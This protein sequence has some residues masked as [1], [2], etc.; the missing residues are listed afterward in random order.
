MSETDF[1]EVTS[2]APLILQVNE[3]RDALQRL[4]VEKRHLE[5]TSRAKSDFFATLSHELRTPLNAILSMI[6]ILGT[7]G[8]TTEQQS[9]LDDIDSASKG[10]LSLINDVLDFSSLEAGHL[11][12]IA[13]AFDFKNVVDEV[14]DHFCHQISSRPVTLEL[15]YD[16]AISQYVIGDPRRVKQVLVNLVANAVKFT[17]RGSVKIIFNNKETTDS[18]CTI[19]LSVS[20]TGIGI[21]TEKIDSIF[22]RFSQVDSSYERRYGSTGLGLPITKQLVEHMGGEILV[23]SQ[24]GQGSEFTCTFQMR[25]QDIDMQNSPWQENHDVRVLVVDDDMQRGKRIS[26]CIAAPNNLHVTSD[27]AFDVIMDAHKVSQPF[28]VFMVMDDIRP[29][30]MSDLC[31]KIKG[32]KRFQNSLLLGVDT[33]AAIDS[34]NQPRTMIDY[35]EDPKELTRL[36]LDAWND[37]S[38]VKKGILDLL[39]GYGAKVLLVEDNLLNQRAMKIMLEEL[40]CT[41]TLA[42]NAQKALEAMNDDYD[43]VFMD[44]GLPDKSGVE[45]V[46]IIRAEK[47]MSPSIPIVA[48]TAHAMEEDKTIFMDAG[49]DDVITK[50]ISLE[51]LQNTLMGWVLPKASS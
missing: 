35:T 14:Y 22:E 23:R 2:Q 9:Y 12:F 10:L 39:R 30:T 19:Q 33:G 16:A 4:E 21:P 34:E 15:E 7:K 6:Q 38:D 18:H 32:R 43:I 26:Q 29:V 36:I 50:P 47:L 48:L 1:K 45:L 46:K 28:Q 31:N 5:N 13:I 25:I 44:I 27:M 3:L 8:L 11:D 42:E 40:A 49:M 20:D 51:N 24:V 17:E 41:V 37:F